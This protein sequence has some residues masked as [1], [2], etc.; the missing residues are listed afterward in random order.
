[1][2]LA[3]GFNN[4]PAGGG[5]F[6]NTG[7]FNNANRQF[8]RKSRGRG[9]RGGGKRGSSTG[10]FNQ[11]QYPNQRGN[12]GDFQQR[13]GFVNGHGGDGG[14]GNFS[15]GRGRGGSSGK[16]PGGLVFADNL[17]SFNMA[18]DAHVT[19][20]GQG[21][22]AVTSWDESSTVFTGGVNGVVKMFNVNDASSVEQTEV[23]VSERSNIF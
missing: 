15:R 7:G 9:G 12:T 22:L 11:P 16:R 3:G 4:S 13:G 1:M 17:L 19:S 20:W 10:G 21:I 23:R 6:N 14:G 5:G 18:V 2:S 8:T